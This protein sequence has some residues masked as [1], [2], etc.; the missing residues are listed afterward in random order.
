VER[1]DAVTPGHH[2]RLH[3]GRRRRERLAQWAQAGGGLARAQVGQRA[4]AG[5]DRLQEYGEGLAAGVH[6]HD[7]EWPAQQRL[8]RGGGL[9]HHELAGSPFARD[10]GVAERQEHV[11]AFERLLPDE[12][13]VP[14]QGHSS[15]R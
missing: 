13:H 8:G 2:Q 6:V 9:D 10:L 5:A 12:R 7:G 4:A 15:S 1:G 3:P 14:V 11:G